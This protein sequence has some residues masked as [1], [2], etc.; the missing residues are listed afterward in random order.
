MTSSMRGAE[1][2][3]IGTTWALTVPTA[4]TARAVW[5][6]DTPVDLAETDTLLVAIDGAGLQPIEIAVTPFGGYDP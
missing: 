5:L 4:G 3:G 6:L 1:T 2:L